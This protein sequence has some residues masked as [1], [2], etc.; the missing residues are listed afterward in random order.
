MVV[1]P[2]G[3]KRTG[4]FPEQ[5]VNWDAYA[6]L[7]AAAERPIRVLN[8]FAYTGGATPG[9]RARRAPVYA[10]WTPV[11]GMVAWGPEKTPRRHGLVG[12]AGTLAR[13]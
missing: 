7:I 8:L 3:F 1:S 5:A 9:L 12:Q 6:R 2:T 4:V 13:G 11:K 10:M